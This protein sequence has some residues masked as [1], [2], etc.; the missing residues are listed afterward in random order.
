MVRGINRK[1]PGEPVKKWRANSKGQ[2]AVVG[3]L[4]RGEPCRSGDGEGRGGLDIETPRWKSWMQ[5][6]YKKNQ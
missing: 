1:V 4:N 5:R 6:S 2:M 3:F